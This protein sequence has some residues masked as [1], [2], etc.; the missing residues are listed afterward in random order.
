M[1]ISKFLYPPSIARCQH[2]KVN[3]VQCGSP[4]LKNRKLCHFHQ[5]WQQEQN[6]PAYA[7]VLASSIW[8]GRQGSGAGLGYKAKEVYKLMLR[9]SGGDPE[10]TITASRRYITIRLPN[11]V[12]EDTARKARTQLLGHGLIE[13]VDAE[14]AQ[15]RVPFRPPSW[16]AALEARLG[17]DRLERNTIRE[18]Q[19][20]WQANDHFRSAP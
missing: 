1:R 19:R 6:L 7:H 4:A 18:I 16:L 14:R 20:H 9:L 12:T 10:R 15:Y 13:A 8:R 3:G 17:T 5:R 11:D 2:V